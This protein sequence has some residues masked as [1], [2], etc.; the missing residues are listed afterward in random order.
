VQYTEHAAGR[1][2]GVLCAIGTV[3]SSVMENESGA[4]VVTS[5]R[6]VK[7]IANELNATAAPALHGLT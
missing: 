3:I 1:S 4:I 5:A 6:D 7:V 2:R